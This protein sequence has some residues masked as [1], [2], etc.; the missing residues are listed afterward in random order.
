MFPSGDQAA[1]TRA[2]KATSATTLPERRL[3]ATNNSPTSARQEIRFDGMEKN[4]A[5]FDKTKYINL[6]LEIGPSLSRY[7]FKIN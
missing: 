5:V 7:A 6:I 1:L 2:I 3:K 4:P